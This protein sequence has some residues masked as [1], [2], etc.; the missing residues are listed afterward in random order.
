[1]PDSDV[2]ISI[3][4]PYY[5]RAEQFARSLLLLGRQTHGA[6]EV[7]VADDGSHQVEAAEV[8]FAALQPF[9]PSPYYVWLLR[10]RGAPPR[11]PN[12]AWNWLFAKAQGDFIITMHPEIMIGPD[13][14]SKM[15]ADHERPFRSVACQYTIGTEYQYNRI[16]HLDWQASLGELRRLPDFWTTAGPWHFD[17]LSAPDYRSHLSFAGNYR[18]DWEFIAKHA[19][20]PF[21]PEVED[22]DFLSDDAW[23]H[24]QELV[25]GRPSRGVDVEVYHQWHERIYRADRPQYSA[26]LR[27]VVGRL[28][29][30]DKD[31]AA[32]WSP[33]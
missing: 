4:I 24:K 16:D 25:L 1:M 11:S 21:L 27:R 17:N 5:N 20:V 19:G 12:T 6:I 28:I 18:E 15:L 29:D 26:R 8:L 10:A 9:I 30:A 23:L 22:P 3:L 32:K 31:A 14:V 13:A 7:L 2:K 33:S